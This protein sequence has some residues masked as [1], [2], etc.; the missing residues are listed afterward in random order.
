MIPLL[1]DTRV[2]DFDI[3]AIQEPWRNK[4]TPTSYCPS[5]LPFYLAYPQ[6]PEAGV[7]CYINKRLAIEQWSVTNHS[8]D[9]QTI[10]IKCAD[11]EPAVE[12]HNIY[13]RSPYSYTSP[14]QGAL[15]TLPEKLRADTTNIVV[16]D[17]N[18]HHPL[19]NG[20]ARPTFHNAAD[21]LLDIAR[22]HSLSLVTPPGMVT[23]NERGSTS[24]IDLTFIS[25]TRADKLIRCETREDVAQDSDHLPVETCMEI[26]TERVAPTRRRNWKKLDPEELKKSVEKTETKVTDLH[27]RHQVDA[28]IKEITLV[29][30]K[31]IDETVPWIRGSSYDKFYWTEE[32][33]EAIE[34][35][36]IAYRNHLREGT[37]ESYELRN[38]A[39][40]RKIAV[41]RRAKREAFREQIAKAT[42]T[43]EGLWKINKWSKQAGTPKA[44]PQLPEIV[45]QDQEGREITTRDLQAK[46]RILRTKFFPEEIR[47]ETSDIDTAE[48][49]EPLTTSDEITED[50][51][52]EAIRTIA[53]KKA[54]GPDQI[55]NAVLKAISSWLVPK[56]A[57]IFTATLRLGYHP[58]EWKRAITLALRKPGKP[59]YRSPT[60]YRP[61]ALLNS[62]GKLLEIVMARRIAE[63]AETWALLPDAQMGARRGRSTLTALQLLT[64]QIHTIWNL[65]G[66]SRVAT[67]LC[68]DIAGAYDNAS[69]RRLL[70]NL[71]K[72][73]IPEIIVRWVASFL[74]E[75]TTNIRVLEGESPYFDVTEGIPQGSPVSPI[76]FLFFIADLLEAIKDEGLRTSPS[77]FVDDTSI[78]TYGNSTEHN[79]EK[80]R[81]VHERC[82]QWALSHGA[83]FAP[84]KY[85]IIHFAKNTRRFNMA[86]TI[87]FEGL[88]PQPKSS[89]RILGVRVD[90]KLKWSAHLQAVKGRYESQLLAFNRITKSTWGASFQKAKLVYSAVLRPT[91]SYA[92]G[93]WYG[94]EGTNLTTKAT[95]RAL[96]TMQNRGLRNVIGAYRAVGGPTLEKETGIPPIS[97]HLEGMVANY[98]KRSHDT[99]ASKYIRRECEK[100]RLRHPTTRRQI[101]LQKTTPMVKKLGWLRD[102]VP[103]LFDSE[104]LRMAPNTHDTQ[105]QG[106][107]K[108]TWKGITKER[109]DAR[110]GKYVDSVPQQRRPPALHAT[111]HNPEKLHEGSS[112]ATSAMITQIRTEKIG[113]NAFL[114]ER[115]VPDKMPTCGCGWPRQTAKHIIRYCPDWEGRREP[116]RSLEDWQNYQK[117]VGTPTGARAVA[118]WLQRTGLLPQFS[119]GL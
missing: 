29:V 86:A 9:Y 82:R 92:A 105:R 75:R 41:I 95:E 51:T 79:C 1:E 15:T 94:P 17:L 66:K 20:P 102:K 23:W 2:H 70:H 31:A 100:I 25:D 98:I 44:L 37:N 61:I 35:S 116:L 8:A 108:T 114:A 74:K 11:D 36:R 26:K 47:A 104:V 14:L 10:T 27:D 103:D 33:S 56:L 65:P 54:P 32:C 64:E 49:P 72:R 81:S 63:L 45:A 91:I 46:L 48:Y 57:P 76:L 112:K 42:S 78:L 96:E 7:C 59:D 39:R 16:G 77:G 4:F 43:T 19:W 88:R 24:T 5:R 50:E 53:S 115:K 60:A 101:T 89:V 6:F 55:P 118:E 38:Q 84:E 113:L 58:R 87:D 12:I 52:Y 119:I 111:D 73:R 110:W 107:W 30:T 62:M 90:S 40:N 28:A 80:L 97:L 85:E 109:W 83:K 68:M 69:R 117:L 106:T 71:R 34:E 22:D 18:L 67:L 21:T 99:P 93:V 3:I 13:N